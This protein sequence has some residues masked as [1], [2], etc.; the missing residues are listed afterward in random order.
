MR[1]SIF[2]RQRCFRT[3]FGENVQVVVARFL[4]HVWSHNFHTRF[5]NRTDNAFP[6]LDGKAWLKRPGLGLAGAS[7]ELQRAQVLIEGKDGHIIKMEGF[8]NEPG[9][10]VI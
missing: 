9:N 1:F 8:L 5:S 4:L 7:P 10:L 6:R 3:C 2:K